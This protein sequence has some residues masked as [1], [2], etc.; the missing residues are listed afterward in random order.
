MQWSV[1]VSE[2]GEWMYGAA[3]AHH[4]ALLAALAAVSLLFSLY[5]WLMRL[6]SKQLLNLFD[7]KSAR[8]EETRRALFPP[9][10]PNGWW[11]LCDVSDLDGGRVHSVSALG[12]DL[13][14]FRGEDGAVGV[15]DAFCPHI[16]AHLGQGGRVVGNTLQCP[17]HG[18]QFDATGKCRH[19]PYCTGQVPAVAR[20]RSWTSCVWTGMVFVWF[21]AEGRPPAY[22]LA[23]IEGVDSSWVSL[24]CKQNFFDQHV[25][26]MAENSADYFHFNYLHAPLPVPLIG[27]FFTVRHETQ[28]YFPE[29][30]ERGH[31]SYFDN[32]AEVWLLNRFRLTFT[33]QKTVVTFEGPS[34]VHFHIATPLGGVHLV[35]TLLPVAPFRQYTEDL[36]LLEPQTPRWLARIVSFIAGGALEQDRQVWQNKRYNAKPVLVKGDG[37][38]P[39]HRR[40]FRQFY[41]ESSRQVAYGSAGP[42]DW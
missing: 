40:W 1:N 17:F 23:P 31:V 12:L 37:P 2:G 25:S 3:Q 30:P 18:W 19:I 36:W 5:R 4:R 21:D 41:S 20:T 16:G 34:V 38:F 24:G 10:Y 39:A 28:L 15:L 8:F 11:K 13:V 42:L 33:R 7:R 35:K 27:R 6:P 9:P 26:E 22:E 32:F 14:V 29:E